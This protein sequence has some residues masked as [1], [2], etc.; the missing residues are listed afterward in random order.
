[1]FDI[2]LAQC[3]ALY[4][5]NLGKFSMGFSV[6]FQASTGL[7]II[8]AIITEPVNLMLNIWLLMFQN[9]I[10]KVMNRFKKSCCYE[11]R[12]LFFFAFI[13]IWN[14]IVFRIVFSCYKVK[15]FLLLNCALLFFS[16]LQHKN[17]KIFL[18][19]PFFPR[20]V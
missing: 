12:G 5:R 9:M 20:V 1:M 11:T 4:L 15:L 16:I 8:T 14:L 10:I 18:F 19:E 3:L 7:K 6:V 13:N 2:S 17:L